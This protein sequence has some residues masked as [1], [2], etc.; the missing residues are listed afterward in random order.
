MN[1][2]NEALGDFVQDVANGGIIRHL[3]DLGYT[4]DEIKEHLTIQ[5][6]DESLMKQIRKRQIENGSI[7]PGLGEQRQNYHIVK[8]QN[9][10]GRISFRRVYDTENTSGM[11]T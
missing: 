6:S 8:E 11:R 9:A 4:P 5:I 2:F 1:Y 10:Y 7:E 3:V